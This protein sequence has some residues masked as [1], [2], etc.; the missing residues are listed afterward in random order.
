MA[1][2]SL[3]QHSVAVT[4]R[5]ARFALFHRARCCKAQ[6]FAQ[7]EAGVLR[8]AETTVSKRRLRPTLLSVQK[9]WLHDSIQSTHYSRSIV[10]LEYGGTNP[11]VQ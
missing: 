9:H 4:G 7:D 8:G 2:A 5:I 11:E 3:L 6:K 1:R 10:W